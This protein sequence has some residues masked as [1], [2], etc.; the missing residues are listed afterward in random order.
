MYIPLY[1]KTNYSLYS[2]KIIKPLKNKA[3]GKE[4]L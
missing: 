1:V 2:K 3:R 4:H